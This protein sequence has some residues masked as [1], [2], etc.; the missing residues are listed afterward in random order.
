MFSKHVDDTFGHLLEDQQ[1]RI[2]AFPQD[3][4]F[5]MTLVGSINSVLKQMRGLL[6]LPRKC[7]L[8]IFTGYIL[9]KTP[10]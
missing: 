7:L 2:R 10:D 6:P 3:K 5:S 9:P 8:L 4:R 1:P